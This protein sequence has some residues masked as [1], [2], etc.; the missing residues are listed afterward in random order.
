MRDVKAR[1]AEAG[2][3]KESSAAGAACA[4][5]FGVEQGR[6]RLSA[7]SAISDSNVKVL[8]FVTSLGRQL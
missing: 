1:R 7:K 4:A 8:I 3:G 2:G 5:R 6:R